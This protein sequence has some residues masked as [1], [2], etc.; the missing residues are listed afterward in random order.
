MVDWEKVVAP[1]FWKAFKIPAFAFAVLVLLLLMRNVNSAVE[2]AYI[3]NIANY[4]IGASVISYGH[5]LFHATWR[6]RTKEDDLPFWA[7]ILAMLIHIVWFA[8]FLWQTAK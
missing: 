4:A 5:F 1:D 2:Y 3:Q 8:W 7:Q 6:K